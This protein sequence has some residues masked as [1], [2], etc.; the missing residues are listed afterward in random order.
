MTIANNGDTAIASTTASTSSTTGALTVAGGAGI[1]GALTVGTTISAGSVGASGTNSTAYTATSAA[2]ATPFGGNGPMLSSANLSS[3]DSTGAW[4]GMSGKNTAGVAQNAYMAVVTNTGA[5]TYA[6]SIV[7]GQQTG[8]TAYAERMRIDQNGNV[9]IGTTTPR[10]PLDVIGGTV[11]SANSWGQDINLVGQDANGPGGADGGSINL[12]VGNGVSNWQNG[13]INLNLGS[14]NHGQV[15]ITGSTNNGYVGFSNTSDQVDHPQVLLFNGFATDGNTVFTTYDVRNGSSGSEQKAYAGAVSTPGS[16]N[17]TPAL[18]WG[19]STSATSYTERMRIDQNGNVGIGTTTPATALDI[20]GA[21]SF[22]GMAAPAVSPAGQGRIYFDSG[23]NQFMVSQNGGAYANLATTGGA[24]SGLSSTAS[25]TFNSNSD[26]LG[27]DGGF[28]FQSNGSNILS[29][30]NSGA[31]TTTG[32]ITGSSALA[33]AAGGAN[34][35]LALSSSGTGSVN[36]GTGN[37]TGLSV[38]D[39]GAGSANYVT[40]KG[41][42]AGSAPAIGTAGSDT[43]ISLVLTPKG[44]GN[45]GIGTTA[46]TATIDIRS[47]TGSADFDLYETTGG[48][49]FIELT[50][51]PRNQFGTTLTGASMG[52][53]SNHPLLLGTA[54]ATRMLLDTNGNVGIGTTVPAGTLDVE[55]GTAASGNGV[56]IVLASQNGQASGNTNGGNILLNPGIGNGTGQWGHVGINT[57]TPN[58]YVTFDVNGSGRYAGTVYIWNSLWDYGYGSNAYNPASASASQPDW[59]LLVSNTNSTAGTVASISLAPQN[60]GSGAGAYIGALMPASGTAAPIVFGQTTSA[61]SYAERMRIDQN[62][63]VGIGTASPSTLLQVAGEI[64][65]SADNTYS[66]GDG[67]LRF[68]SVYAVNGAI[69]TSDRR[70]KKDIQPSDLGLDFIRKLQPVSYHWNNGTD[71]DLHYGLIAQDTER[72]VAE[73]KNQS[74][75]KAVDASNTIVEHDKKTDRYGLK[76]TELIS[77]IIKAVQ[78]LYDKLVGVDRQIASVKADNARLEAEVQ[79]LKQDNAEMKARL[80]K[81]EK[82]LKAH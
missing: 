59:Q 65:P 30:S 55:G 33:V 2:S 68:T 80:E 50:G 77:P 43:N 81:I 21:E 51:G 37:G 74:G 49:R 40:V 35:N 56:N 14:S 38:L 3:T 23:A 62:G 67:A 17:H 58:Q 6:P 10:G 63:N 69:Q 42:A 31:I 22:R 15:T 82:S 75:D 16:T 28:N 76:Y 60:N 61:T 34:Q 4:L 29:V 12:T 78:E 32:N 8:A 46:P 70:Q 36:V 44:T 41:A 53:F 11:P 54:N 73:A 5:G 25:E 39:T 64:S 45:V 71:N 47:A 66:L 1:A 18:V 24:G 7:I 48:V 72:A 79:Q 27:T 20:S 57:T 9:G 52:T 19:Q 13:S 26:G